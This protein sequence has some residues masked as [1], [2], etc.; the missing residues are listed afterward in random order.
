MKNSDELKQNKLKKELNILV[1]IFIT[2]LVLYFSLKDHFS[3]TI[4]QIFTM[5][6]WYLLVAFLLLFLFW[7]FR[8]YPMYIFCKK[9]NKDFKYTSAFQL[10]LRTQFFNAVTPFA[11]GGQPYQIYYL[12]QSGIDY[13]SSTSVVLENFIVYQ[14]ALVTLG[15][16]ALF[17]NNVFH[18]FNKVY[19]LQKLVALGFVMN[20]LVIVVMFILAF[21]KKI[22]KF[23]INLG[24]TILTKFHIVKD[25]NK[26]LEE[27][28]NN[29]THFHESA[30]LLLKDKRLFIFNIICNFIA[31][32]CLYL[33]PLFVLYSMGNTSAFNPGVG[34][35]TSAYIMIIG[36]FVP[37]PGGSGGLEY[38]FV[39]FYGNFI[40]GGTLSAMMLVWRFITYYFG[41]IVGAIA[42]NIKRVK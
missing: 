10:T 26:K 39:Q 32:C 8:T 14:I 3:E 36:S 33:I 35:F 7:I 11:T 30:K 20:T 15:L 17:T 18:I 42:L 41:M 12:K 37:I 23:L 25:K 28:D 4:N 9:I 40:S 19:L 5:N 31:L 1:L 24:I 13:A 29:I 34:I 22:S 21:S 16:I 6:I 2:I 27:W 38:G